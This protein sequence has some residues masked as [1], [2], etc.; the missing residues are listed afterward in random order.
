[1]MHGQKNIKIVN[2]M[3]SGLEILVLFVTLFKKLISFYT[4]MQRPSTKKN[5]FDCIN[6]EL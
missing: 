2:V 5:F 3:F 4:Y 6:C 1:M